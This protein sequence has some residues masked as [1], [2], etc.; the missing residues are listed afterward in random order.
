VFIQAMRRGDASFVVPFFYSTLIFAG[1]YDFLVFAVTPTTAGLI[2]ASL[3]VIG[4]IVIA[5]REQVQR[6]RAAKT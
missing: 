4:A 5:W 1:I 3:I 2:G 6:K